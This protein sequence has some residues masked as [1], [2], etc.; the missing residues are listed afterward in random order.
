MVTRLIKQMIR[1]YQYENQIFMQCISSIKYNT[2]RYFICILACALE[3]L[4]GML[5]GKGP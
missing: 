1:L 2:E 5:H 3:I 4:M